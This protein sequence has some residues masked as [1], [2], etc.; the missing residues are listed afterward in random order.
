[1][2]GPRAIIFDFNGVILDDEP[3]HCA[4]MQEMLAEKGTGSR[5]RSTGATTWPWTTG[6]PLPPPSGR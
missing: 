3:V 2:S 4:T 5:R 1:M 6:G